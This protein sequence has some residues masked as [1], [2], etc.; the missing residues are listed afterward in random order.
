MR[1]D[2]QERVKGLEEKLDSE[3]DRNA[4][5]FLELDEMQTTLRARYSDMIVKSTDPVSALNRSRHR[6]AVSSICSILITIRWE[7]IDRVGG[8]DRAII[9]VIKLCF[10]HDARGFASGMGGVINP[11][12]LMI[13]YP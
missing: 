9:P 3:R 11:F 1:C 8:L 2:W 13:E 5:L 6:C 12:N 4:R 7:G 10:S